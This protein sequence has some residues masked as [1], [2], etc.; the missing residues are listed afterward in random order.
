[1]QQT[2]VLIPGAA[3]GPWYWHLVAAELNREGHEVVTPD[4]P[5]DDDRAGLDRYVDV[6]ESAVGERDGIVAVGQS[7]G[8]LSAALL[9]ARRPVERLVLVAPMIPRPGE[10][11]GEWWANTG[12][13]EAA[14]RQAEELGIAL[15]PFDPFVVY[16]HDVPAELAEESGRHVREQ[17]GRPF[18]DPWPL[19]KWPD[20]DTRVIAGRYDRLFP[21]E[22]MRRVSRE[23]LGIEPEVIDSGHLPALS[24]PK[25]LARLLMR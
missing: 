6:V 2:F 24:Q 3:S 19:G 25:E 5:T 14:H 22:F 17:S 1:M 23:R 12:Q 10:T 9:S 11:G 7:M 15:E 21:L 20:V 13:P 16:L 8:A 18:A 4:L